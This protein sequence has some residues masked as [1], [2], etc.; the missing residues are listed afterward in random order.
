[1]K[2]RGSHAIVSGQLGDLYIGSFGEDVAGDEAGGVG[3]V[4]LVKGVNG[5]FGLA[6]GHGFEIQ[7]FSRNCIVPRMSERAITMAQNTG[8]LLLITD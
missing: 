2:D 1:M 3:S 5:G 4:E 7:N 6:S 8:V